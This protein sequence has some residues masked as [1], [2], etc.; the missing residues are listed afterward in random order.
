MRHHGPAALQRV[1]QALD[2]ISAE[3]GQ[4]VKEQYAVGGQ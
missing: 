2:G 4:L 3:L 1:P